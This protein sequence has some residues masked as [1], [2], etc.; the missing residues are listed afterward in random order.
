MA[1]YEYMRIPVDII[2]Q[3]IMD[4]Y[5]LQ[6]LV[7][8]GYVYVEIRKG[9]YGLPQAGR[10]ANDALVPHLASHGYFQCPHTPG[11]FKHESRPIAF[12]LIMDDFGVKYVGKKHANHLISTLASKYTITKDWSGTHYCGL[13][14]KWDYA[15]GT[16]DV[17]MPGY[18][19]RALQHFQH[20][21][22]HRDEHSPH[23]WKPPQY[24]VAIQL[25]DLPDTTPPLPKQGIKT[26]Q[27]IVGVLLFYARTVD[28][29][30][31]LVLNDIGAEQTKGTEMTMNAC[32]RL[33]NY[34]AT[35]PDA[36]IQFKRS[37]MI[38][39]THTN[40]S[41]LTA[42]QAR[43]RAGGYHFLGDP[44]WTLTSSMLPS[45]SS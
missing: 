22:P 35:H 24:G 32:V 18:V 28:N 26:I 9:M 39:R 31:L 29:T 12:S 3:D 5:N 27:E 42:P 4:Q 38:L 36:T 2:P 8:G 10:I 37:D 40:A 25:T 34:A 33:L 23:E 43:S 41:Y 11:L 21:Q 45:M 7:V 14:L 1:R 16:V 30:M 19:D 17:S 6:E 13:T 20:P 15:K 44:T